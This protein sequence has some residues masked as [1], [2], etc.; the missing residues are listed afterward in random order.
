MAQGEGMFSFW[1]SL[2]RPARWSL[3]LG[4]LA[5][6]GIA[7]LVL[8]WAL[9]TDYEVLFSQLAEQDAAAIVAQLKR[10]KVEFELAEAGTTVLVPAARVH[11]TRLGLMSSGVP[12]TGGVGFELFD[13]QGLGTTE[14]SQRVSYQRALQGELTRTIATLDHVQAA[15][16]HLVL[17]ES[18]LFRRD[19]QEPRGAVTLTLKPGRDISR[20]QISGIQRLVAA[21]VAGL[22]PARV[23]VTD[24]RGITLSG[25]EELG[26]SAGGSEA[27]F[28]TKREIESY[29]A[30]KVVSLLDGA[31]GPGQAIVSVDVALNFDEIR[32]TIQNRAPD[33][34]A[35][36]SYD[37]RVEEV[38]AA[39]GGIT[40]ISVG[41][42]VP[43]TLDDDRRQRI[44]ALVRMAAGIDDVR[45]DAVVVQPLADI[46]RYSAA[47]SADPG[48]V[49]AGAANSGDASELPAPLEVPVAA[50]APAK[51][52]ITFDPLTASVLWPLLG[53]ALLALLALRF[54]VMRRATRS[55]RPLSSQARQKMLAQ[56]RT[57]LGDPSPTPESRARS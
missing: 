46:G 35:S 43:G 2:E 49:V 54:V 1:N 26:S 39:P 51:A 8:W 11:E 3:G 6:L 44:V 27:R 36:A 9:R 45:G 37:R 15:R 38:I 4:A 30:R 50:G 23:V 31:Y 32:R 55:A 33:G 20:D 24:Q 12:L 40:R 42:I 19:R 5:C 28:A 29:V 41:V 18:S 7:A 56:M 16:V 13:R 47:E 57:V 17:P 53:V 52:A 25:G 21:S 10:Q 48:A 22:D 34:T 14:Q